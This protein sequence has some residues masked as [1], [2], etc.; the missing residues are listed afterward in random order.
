MIKN[1]QYGAFQYDKLS[2]N[3]NSGESNRPKIYYTII[4]GI[5]VLLTTVTLAVTLHSSKSNESTGNLF[6]YMLAQ[7]KQYNI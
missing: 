6:L 7:R 3:E 1:P 4:F 2:T 5:F